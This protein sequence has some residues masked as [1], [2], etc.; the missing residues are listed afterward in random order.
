MS[1][2]FSLQKMFA[3]DECDCTFGHYILIEIF[4]TDKSDP[5]VTRY[6]IPLPAVCAVCVE[7]NAVFVAISVIGIHSI[8]INP[9][10][11]LPTPAPNKGSFVLEV[12][13]TDPD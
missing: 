12:I 13:T 6:V 7:L 4:F 5:R 3:Y 8:P 11:C 1:K 2:R 10:D 9:V